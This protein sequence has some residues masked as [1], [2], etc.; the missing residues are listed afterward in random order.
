MLLR[1]VACSIRSS[2][3][4]IGI[5]GPHNSLRVP[6]RTGRREPPASHSPWPEH[7]SRQMSVGDLT[8]I[9]NDTNIVT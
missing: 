3:R 1:G 7:R 9:V 4:F 6:V 5:Q 8:Q 2:G